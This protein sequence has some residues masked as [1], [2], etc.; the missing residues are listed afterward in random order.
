MANHNADYGLKLG[1]SWFGYGL[2]EV[3][4]DSAAGLSWVRVD[5]KPS[6]VKLP[7]AVAQY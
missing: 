1:S 4:A 6:R 3:Q 5:S 7:P 2:T